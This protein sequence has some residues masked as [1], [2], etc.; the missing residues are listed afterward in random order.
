[1]YMKQ[2][3][4]LTLTDEEMKHIEYFTRGWQS[5]NLWWEYKKRKTLT[6]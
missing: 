3:M 1:M 5:S 2:M 4:T 6:N